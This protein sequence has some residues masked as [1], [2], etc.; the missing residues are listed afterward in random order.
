MNRTYIEP[1]SGEA[2]LYQWDANHGGWTPD[3]VA[4][5]AW[6]V[7]A[8]RIYRST[9]TMFVTMP[10][11]VRRPAMTEAE[12]NDVC[13]LASKPWIPVGAA[14]IIAETDIPQYDAWAADP[15][16]DI[17]EENLRPVLFEPTPLET[18]YFKSHNQEVIPTAPPQEPQSQP[19][20]QPQPQEETSTGP[21][22]PRHVATLV[23]SNALAAAA[24][25]PIS[26]EP[27][28]HT[29]SSVTG[30]GHVFQTMALR[31]WLS[32]H[33]ICPE[34]RTPTGATAF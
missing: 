27:I 20:P 17:W 2:L 12:L 4:M 24:T 16:S 26:M 23:L 9:P 6:R 29:G 31:Q 8:L 10:G 21:T 22:L 25:C 7:N 28:Q 34:C 19:Q 32:N 11:H 14:T 5:A 13:G 33:A 18:V 1:S 3:T 15:D 30:C